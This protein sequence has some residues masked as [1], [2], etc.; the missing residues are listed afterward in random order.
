MGSSEVRRGTV[1]LFW[2]LVWDAGNGM[3][4]LGYGATLL[5]IG[6]G[7]HSQYAQK[8]HAVPR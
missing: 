1:C 8:R 6:S 7:T 3:S 5:L 2:L 4:F